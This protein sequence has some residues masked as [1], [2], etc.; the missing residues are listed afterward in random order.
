MKAAVFEEFGKLPVVKEVPDPTP[1]ADSVVIDVKANGVCRSDWHA[2]I[3]HDP[4]ITLPHVPGHELA[5]VVSAVG[6]NVNNIATGDRVTVPF[7]CGCGV[8]R[9]CEQ[10][11][12][13]ICNDD[14][15][16][17]FTHWG[18]F[19][20]RVEIHYASN[21]VVKLP[22]ELDFVTAASLGCRFATAYRAVVQQA[23]LEPNQWLA[24]HGCGGL[25]L[26]AIMIAKAMGARVIAIDI[27][28]QKLELAKELGA[29]EIVNAR[30]TPRVGKQVMLATNGGVDASI[31]A[32]GIT[33]TAVNSVKSLRKQGRHI[34]AGLLLDEH[35]TPPLPMGRVIAFELELLGSHGMSARDYPAMLEMVVSGKIPLAKLIGNRIPLSESPRVLSEMDSFQS[36]GVTVIDDFSS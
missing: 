22:D 9:Y 33:E 14:F 2:W 11:Q 16:P 5:G 31:D 23:H 26:S 17:G 21:N 7:S 15:Q 30:E 24:V 1:S 3:G 34:Q 19:A 20:E 8:C 27:T 4:T 29:D 35:A 32:L 10:G 12:L 36:V 28:D 13:Q 6:A 25:G 18:S